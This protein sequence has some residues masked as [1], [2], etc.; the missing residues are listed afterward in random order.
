MNFR[1]NGGFTKGALNI[2][3]AHIGTTPKI[4]H[5][6]ETHPFEMQ[7]CVAPPRCVAVKCLTRFPPTCRCGAVGRRLHVYLLR[8]FGENTSSND[9]PL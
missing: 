6:E 9:A 1:I 4:A 7:F 5:S 8:P 3:H 2:A